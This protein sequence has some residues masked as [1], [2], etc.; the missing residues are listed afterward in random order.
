M[1]EEVK[2]TSNNL[3]S[4]VKSNIGTILVIGGLAYNGFVINGKREVEKYKADISQDTLIKNQKEMKAD[5]KT[6]QNAI[7]L[8]NQAW[9]VFS[10]KY[11]IDKKNAVELGEK[12]KKSIVVLDTAMDKHLRQTNRIEERFQFLKDQLEE[13]KNSSYIWI[14]YST[15]NMTSI[16]LS[17]K[18]QVN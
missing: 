8:Q 18:I 10:S 3:W 9:T 17:R 2:I 4:W 16:L 7:S 12:I 1:A 15:Q 5:I 14:P 6:I 13:K 11:D